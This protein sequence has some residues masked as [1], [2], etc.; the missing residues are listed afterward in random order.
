MLVRH[1]RLI[2]LSGYKRG[3][4]LKMSRKRSFRPVRFVPYEKV[5]RAKRIFDRAY[6]HYDKGE[7][8]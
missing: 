7:V 8:D 2:Q 4:Q 3:Y 6:V 5:V 1:A